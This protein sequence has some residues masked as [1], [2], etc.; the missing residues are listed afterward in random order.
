MLYDAE[1]LCGCCVWPNNRTMQNVRTKTDDKENQ[2]SFRDIVTAGTIAFER[3]Q[4][5]G[6]KMP[7][8]NWKEF[9]KKLYYREQKEK[10]KSKRSS[11]ATVL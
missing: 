4:F 1:A 3:L 7:K 11:L 2:C 5:S 6:K 9:K 8:E 10:L